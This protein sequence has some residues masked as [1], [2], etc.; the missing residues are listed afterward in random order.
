MLNMACLV[1]VSGVA[2]V[3]SESMLNTVCLVS[4]SGV[5]CLVSE[6]MFTTLFYGLNGMKL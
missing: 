6:S 4:V 1:S 2:C 3:V 5:A